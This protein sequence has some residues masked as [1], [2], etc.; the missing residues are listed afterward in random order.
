VPGGLREEYR[1][2]DNKQKTRLRNEVRKRTHLNPESA[3]PQA[4]TSGQ[5]AE[6]SKR[7]HEVVLLQNFFDELRR[8]SDLSRR[9]CRMT[10]QVLSRPRYGK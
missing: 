3:D 4:G 7:E 8:L 10:G 1:P 6:S 9:A 2:A 5:G